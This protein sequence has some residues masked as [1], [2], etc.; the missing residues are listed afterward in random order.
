MRYALDKIRNCVLSISLFLL[1]FH[2]EYNSKCALAKF[3][4]LCFLCRKESLIPTDDQLDS[5]DQLD[6]VPTMC[7]K[8]FMAQVNAS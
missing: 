7:N 5:D 8:H 6:F 1:P 4:L 3:R 2:Y